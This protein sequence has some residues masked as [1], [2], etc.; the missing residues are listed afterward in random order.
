MGHAVK[1][2]V[3]FVGIAV[4]SLHNLATIMLFQ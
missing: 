4:A 2:D 1:L 3:Q